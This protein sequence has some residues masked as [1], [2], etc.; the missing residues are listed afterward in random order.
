MELLKEFSQTLVAFGVT[1]SQAGMPRPVVLGVSG[2]PDS[3]AMLHLFAR[4]RGTLNVVPV[5]VHVDHQIRGEAAR[6]DAAF[7]AETA[8][9]WGVPVRVEQ[10][11]VPALAAE[12]RLSLEEAARQ[13]RY[14]A[15]GQAAAAAGARDISV[16]HNLDD[17]AE[18]VLMHLLRGAGLAG[19]RGMLPAAPLSEYHLLA[20]VERDIRIIRPLLGVPR[21]RIE[22]YCAAYGL[23]PRFDRSNLDTTFFRN[24]LRR[25]IIPMLEQ[26]NPNLRQTLARTASVLA[27]DYEIV[28]Q[29]V[30]AAWLGVTL[31]VSDERVRFA[32]ADWRSLPL[33]VQRSLVRRAV[34]VLRS[35]LRDVSFEH[36]EAAIEVAQNGLTG[37]EATLPGG[38]RLRVGYNVLDVAGAGSPAPRPDWPLLEPGS[39]VE[40]AVP[41]VTDLPGTGWRFE[42]VRYYGPRGGPGWERLLADP[43]AVPL[44]A[45][46]LDA[47]LTL[48]TRQ[49]GDRFTPMGVGGRKKVSDFMIDQ[50][51]PAD[52]RD[53]LPLLVCGEAIVW[54]CGWR[55]DARYA[56]EPETAD[57]WVARFTGE[58]IEQ[59]AS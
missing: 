6:A 27:A 16:A 32:L 46:R 36:V 12:R 17:Q 48:R 45:G 56:V 51:I 39:R 57:V 59:A 7:V 24:R 42:I 41:G 21:A 43:W 20:P 19:L 53:G 25:E 31:E 4:A 58:G 34:W 28:R 44:N 38:L 33:G 26:V 40:V 54:V 11:D 52:W 30:D 22:A 23:Q 9:A 37:A 10:V 55:V 5:A 8:N 29:E 50:K 35:G 47:P 2:G 13:A 1:G 15:L 3:L 14:T 18:T 49:P